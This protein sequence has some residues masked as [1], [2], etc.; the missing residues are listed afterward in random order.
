MT[1]PALWLGAMLF[2]QVLA[3]AGPEASATA[4]DGAP[5]GLR[6]EAAF[7]LLSHYLKDATGKP[8]ILAHAHEVSGFTTGHRLYVRYPRDGGFQCISI[9]SGPANEEG[10]F[11][12]SMKIPSS[13][14]ATC[15]PDEKFVAYKELDVM[16]A[17][18]RTCERKGE[19]K[20]LVSDPGNNNR[21]I[22]VLP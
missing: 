6:K 9:D 13:A 1:C 17:R 20:C 8:E 12:F 3:A 21:K 22:L 18:V 2:P 14:S 16:V 7:N 5:S 10:K 15:A 4:P 11:R 19:K